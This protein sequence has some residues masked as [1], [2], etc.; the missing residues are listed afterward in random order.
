MDIEHKDT[1]FATLKV[2]YTV[3]TNLNCNGCTI[4]KKNF[5]NII[6]NIS[7]LYSYYL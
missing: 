2:Q 4:G 6:D 5:E 1:D 7:I 3:D